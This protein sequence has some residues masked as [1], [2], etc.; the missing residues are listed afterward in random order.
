M[1]PLIWIVPGY[2]GFMHTLTFFPN[3]LIGRYRFLRMLTAA[4][5]VVSPLHAQT[6]PDHIVGDVGGAV[7]STQSVVTG[8]KDMLSALPYAYFD[9]GRFFARVDTFGIKTWPLGYGHLELATR[10]SFEGFKADT[11]PLRG[12]QD[13]ANPLPVGIGTFQ[14]TPVGGFFFNALRDTHSGGSLTE[15]TWATEFALGRGQVYPQLGVERR[16]ARYVQSLYGVSASESL[17]SGYKAYVPGASTMPVVGLG[18]DWPVSGSWVL[19]AQ[20]RR[21]FLDASLRDSP[22]VKNAH[23]DSGYLALTYRFK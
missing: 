17:A 3:F 23:Q 10:I 15:F 8:Q 4:C 19:N 6:L 14:E 9:Y 11:A 21:K 22:L 1:C 2:S 7:Y 13:R 16:S 12:I 5:G 18:A 20:W